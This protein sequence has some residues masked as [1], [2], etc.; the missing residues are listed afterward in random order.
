[1]ALVRTGPLFIPK[2]NRPP[3]RAATLG[4]QAKPWP[5]TLYRQLSSYRPTS[6]SRNPSAQASGRGVLTDSI[7]SKPRAFN[8]EK[9]GIK[10]KTKW[11]IIAFLTIAATLETIMYIKL[12]IRWWKNTQDIDESSN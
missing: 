2:L 1:M 4:N 7:N 6:K 10:G 11:A 9:L 8:F 12:G 3:L 5:D